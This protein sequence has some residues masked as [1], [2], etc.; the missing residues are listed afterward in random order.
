MLLRITTQKEPPLPSPGPS[1]RPGDLLALSS[2]PFLPLSLH[3]LRTRFFLFPP[4]LISLS[5]THYLKQLTC[6]QSFS[7]VRSHRNRRFCSLSR[8]SGDSVAMSP[9]NVV[10]G[11]REAVEKKT[12]AIR[13]AGASKLQVIA[14]FDG[15]LTKYSIDGRRGQSMCLVAKRWIFFSFFLFF[16]PNKYYDCGFR[17]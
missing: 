11:D 2:S 13:A 5:I 16:F 15:T 7:S 14:D 4:L 17:V 10:I 12:A 3:F 9:D 6:I 1:M 8:G